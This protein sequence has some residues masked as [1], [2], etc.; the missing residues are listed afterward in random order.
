M[1]TAWEGGVILLAVL[2]L[3]LSSCSQNPYSF[4]PPA[5][6]FPVHDELTIS[7]DSNTDDP[8]EGMPSVR[9]IQ[10]GDILEKPEIS[11]ARDGYEFTGWYEE[12]SCKT[13]YTFAE[14]VTDD[15]ILY[16]GWEE[17]LPTVTLR[18]VD[19]TGAD[20]I[21]AA[22]IFEKRP[23][24]A[25]KK[26]DYLEELYLL[27]IWDSGSIDWRQL[28]TWSYSW[29]KYEPVSFPLT[30]DEDITLYALCAYPQIDSE[31]SGG[32]IPEGIILRCA[33]DFFYYYI[34]D[35]SS[36][37]LTAEEITLPGSINGYPVRH[38]SDMT[39]QNNTSLRTVIMEAG[40]EETGIQSFF[41]CANLSSVTFPE[42]LRIIDDLAFRGTA[43]ASVTIPSYAEEISSTAFTFASSA[44]SS[45]LREIIFEG[46]E[47][48]ALTGTLPSAPYGGC[49]AY[50]PDEAVSA[51]QSSQ[52]A[53]MFTI[54]PVSERQ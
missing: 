45:G 52:W 9:T 22:E 1:H 40:I 14:P 13:E 39:F 27:D 16:A 37:A 48:P 32:L 28:G 15:L 47:P 54:S 3:I 11:P 8:V 46:A 21:P 25:P 29:D 20:F 51:Y 24:F 49:I 26:T 50:V 19:M 2:I 6:F 30:V 42:T 7:F 12:S 33:T 43:L 10:R 41:N 23:Y 36:A 44:E 38:I 17:E 35:D 53:E 4:I 31:T 18:A 5:L 34:D